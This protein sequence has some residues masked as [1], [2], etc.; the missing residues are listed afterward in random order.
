LEVT[1]PF[2]EVHFSDGHIAI[3]NYNS[4]STTLYGWLANG[5][6]LN[7]RTMTVLDDMTITA[8]FTELGEAAIAI[9]ESV[10]AERGSQ[11][12]TV[13]LYV[14]PNGASLNA[15]PP[16]GTTGWTVAIDSN[17]L[18]FS[19]PANAAVGDYTIDLTAT[20]NGYVRCQKS[21]T[22][23]VTAPALPT[24]DIGAPSG[25]ITAEQ[26]SQARVTINPTPSGAAITVNN[27]PTGWGTPTVSGNQVVINVPAN[28]ALGNNTITLKGT[29][30]G[31]AE[32][33]ATITVRVI[34]PTALPEA[35]IDVSN[36]V[37]AV[38]GSTGNTISFTTTPS[39]ATLTATGP[40]GWS[41]SVSGGT[42]T[43]SVPASAAP[44][45]YTINLTAS[46]TGYEAGHAT[47]TVHVANVLQFTNNPS[48][49]CTIVGASS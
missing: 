3:C 22:V 23:H 1:S 35:G 10:T 27:K 39:D 48:A 33:T 46:K 20:S 6:A 31:Y 49:S 44:G 16:V 25:T 2:T 30:D 14:Y 12:N 8:M 40:P 34:E 13:P 7:E 47:V 43:Y 38:K 37:S 9:Q 19:V 21:I 15:V 11:N 36:S 42:I 17:A 26:G 29:A 32:G 4:N 24:V 45:D 18:T 41:F 5:E 28:A